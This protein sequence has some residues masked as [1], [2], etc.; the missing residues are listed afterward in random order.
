MTA[1]RTNR[2]L[3]FRAMDETLAELGI[4]LKLDRLDPH[5][6]LWHKRHGDLDVHDNWIAW[7]EAWFDEQGGVAQGFHSPWDLLRA[8]HRRKVYELH[9]PKDG[10]PFNGPPE[11]A[12]CFKMTA[13][14]YCG[15]ILGGDGGPHYGN[16]S[17]HVER[18][19]QAGMNIG[20]CYATGAYGWD[21]MDAQE[22]ACVGQALEECQLTLDGGYVGSIRTDFRWQGRC[23]D[24]ESNLDGWRKAAGVAGDVSPEELFLDRFEQA[25]ES[26]R[27]NTP[28]TLNTLRYRFFLLNEEN[29]R[30]QRSRTPLQSELDLAAAAA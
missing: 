5:I 10:N 26:A 7:Q 30:M 13:W 16:I 9:K 1:N 14:A 25:L 18:A 23:L 12:F 19:F 2:P 28:V 22:I 24:Y 3:G 17:D 11:D 21:D 4:E 20:R 27:S 15:A 29:Q 8:V 6:R